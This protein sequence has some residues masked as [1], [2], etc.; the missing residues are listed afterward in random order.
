MNMSKTSAIPYAAHRRRL[1][2]LRGMPC[3]LCPK[4]QPGWKTCAFPLAWTGI[5]L[6]CPQ[7][8]GWSN[9]DALH[10]DFARARL[11]TGKK[12]SCDQSVQV[13]PEVDG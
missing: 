3:P 8:H 13:S 4:P 1:Y 7:G 6:A 9:V 10:E 5:S 11:S 12:I 2:L